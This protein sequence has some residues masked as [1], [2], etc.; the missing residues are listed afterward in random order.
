MLMIRETSNKVLKLLFSL[1]LSQIIYIL[2]LSGLNTELH[3]L[4]DF[5]N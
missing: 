4:L 1:S 3:D 2:I 5:P